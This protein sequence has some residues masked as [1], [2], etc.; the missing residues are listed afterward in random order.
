MEHKGL[1]PF[2]CCNRMLLGFAAEVY[3]PLCLEDIEEDSAIL[4][5]WQ[6]H[7]VGVGL[8]PPSW[9]RKDSGFDT[10]HRKSCKRSRDSQV[11]PLP[12][13]TE[14]S[15]SATMQKQSLNVL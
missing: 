9:I 1:L 7:P 6:D 11:A 12:K 4:V 5:Q 3:T 13:Y 15:Q 2:D 10:I 14:L 8:S